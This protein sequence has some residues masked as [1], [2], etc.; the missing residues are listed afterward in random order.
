M[1]VKEGIDDHQSDDPKLQCNQKLRI[2]TSHSS[3]KPLARMV[4]YLWN[5]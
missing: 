1:K 2:E 4:S 3:P 5:W